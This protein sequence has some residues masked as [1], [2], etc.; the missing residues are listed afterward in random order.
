[1]RSDSHAM[2]DISCD[3]VTILRISDFSLVSQMYDTAGDGHQTIAL[4]NA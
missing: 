4:M 1:M 2:K 3:I